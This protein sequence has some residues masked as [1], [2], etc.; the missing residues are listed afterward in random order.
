[1]LYYTKGELSFPKI[2]KPVLSVE[3]RL[4]DMQLGL[5]ILE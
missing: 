4:G 5:A 3:V 2:A 1:M